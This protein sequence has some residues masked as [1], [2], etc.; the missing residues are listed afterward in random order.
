MA[1]NAIAD[2][3]AAV[4]ND[5]ELQGALHA[6]LVKAAP[7]VVV[8]IARQKGFEFSADELTAL[9]DDAALAGVVGGVIAKPGTTTTTTTR[10]IKKPP[11]FKLTIPGPSFVRVAA[12]EEQNPAETD[13]APEA[14]AESAADVYEGL[15]D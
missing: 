13:G 12:G 2:F 10:P 6:A 3:F 9:L 4:Y 1:T 14:P 5:T 15:L 8:E 11:T 7:A